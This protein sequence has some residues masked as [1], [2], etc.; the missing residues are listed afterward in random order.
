MQENPEDI[1][2]KFYSGV[3]WK[4][5]GEHTE[6]ARRWEDLIPSAAQYVQDCRLRVLR[7]IPASGDRLL[8][9]ASGPIQYPEYLKY[10]ENFNKRYCVDL[11]ENAL[12]VAKQKLGSDGEYFHGSFFDLDFEEDSFDC[13]LSLHTIYHMDKE[14]QEEA[15]R[16]LIKVT[17]PGQPVIIVYGNPASLVSRLM[18][19]TIIK[20]LRGIKSNNLV[21]KQTQDTKADLYFFLHPLD[22]WDR[23]SDTAKVTVYPW[24]SFSADAQKKLFPSNSLGTLLLKLLFRL[25]DRFPRL[26]VKQAQYPMIVLTKK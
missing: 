17:K 22:W 3:G 16:K 25:E 23:F 11:S 8:D 2:R 5:V 20:K 4:Q 24:R 26:F 6:D 21:I 1:V 7:H 14:K 10:S 19:L 9:M 15:V 12:A 13:S 18:S